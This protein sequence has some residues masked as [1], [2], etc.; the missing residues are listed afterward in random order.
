MRTTLSAAM[1]ASRVLPSPA[2]IRT[3]NHARNKIRAGRPD[4]VSG[5]RRADGLQLNVF[6]PAAMAEAAHAT[7][8]M[9]LVI[10]IQVDFAAPD[11][12]M[13]R[14]G[15]DLSDAEAAIEHIATLLAAAR[16]AG[17]PIGFARVVTRP[18]TDSRALRLLHERTGRD[19]SSAAICRDDSA[20]AD[21]YAL[22]PEPG[23]LEIAKPLYS[24]FVGTALGPILAAR[25]IDTLVVTGMTT[26]CCVDSTVRDAFH[27]DINVFLV[28][29]ACA[30][31][32][33]AEHVASLRALGSNCAVL[34]DS[35]TVLAGWTR[36]Q[37]PP[38]RAPA[39]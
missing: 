36:G 5:I 20:G 34:V 37:P 12:A 3:G 28:A 38:R 39:G 14:F 17:V 18:E 1:V 31:Y 7:R 15:L 10:D 22:H 23:D 32:D 24:C 26:E 19:A 33:R 11:G 21:Y 16:A 2:S 30:A 4:S 29:D 25:G 6:T 13:G 8:T 27:R 35:D 9:L